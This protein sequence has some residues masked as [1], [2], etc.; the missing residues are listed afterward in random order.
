MDCFSAVG[1]SPGE[2]EE[3][4]RQ[5]RV[6]QPVVRID[7]ATN[8]A[9]GRSALVEHAGCVIDGEAARLIKKRIT[10]PM[11]GELGEVEGEVFPAL[12][13]GGHRAQRE[14]GL[15]ERGRKQCRAV[16]GHAEADRWHVT[17]KTGLLLD[18]ETKIAV[19]LN[20][21][22]EVRRGEHPGFRLPPE[23]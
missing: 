3:V 13:L 5:E 9:K 10:A 8:A 6:H 2:S 16:P 11:L 14:H 21:D 19:R 17:A 7:L 23:R 15:I 12:G 22:G 4:L 18:P 20:Y 1:S